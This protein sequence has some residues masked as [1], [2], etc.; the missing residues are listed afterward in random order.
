MVFR[1]H[2]Y[3]YE[4]LHT[5]CTHTHAFNYICSAVQA[6]SCI[7]ED[8]RRRSLAMHLQGQKLSSE[9]DLLIHQFTMQH[10]GLKSEHLHMLADSWLG[11]V[12]ARVVGWRLKLFL[13]GWAVHV[14]GKFASQPD[15]AHPQLKATWYLSSRDIMQPQHHACWSWGVLHW[16]MMTL[17][18]WQRPHPEFSMWVDVGYSLWSWSLGEASTWQNCMR[19]LMCLRH[20]RNSWKS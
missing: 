9:T 1:Y 10:W 7:Q 18:C 8:A 15:W 11:P 2:I 20:F 4:I 6:L 14:W 12:I 5:V 17:Q 16:R 19:T 13:S 3:V